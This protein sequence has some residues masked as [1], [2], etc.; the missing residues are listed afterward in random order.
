MKKLIRNAWSRKSGE[1][2][3]HAKI[4]HHEIHPEGLDVNRIRF[5]ESGS[6]ALE[7]SVGHLISMLRGIGRFYL[8]GDHQH[9]LNMQASVHAYIPPGSECILEAEPETELI[10]ISSPSSSQARGKKLVLRDE[11]YLAACATESQSLRWILTPQYL[12][13]RIFLHHDQ[14]LLSKAGN[15]ISLFHTTMFDV[16]GLPKNEEGESVFKMSY[17]SRTEV[18]FCYDV[19]GVARVRMAQHPYRSSKQ[20]WNPW[21]ALDGDSTYHLNEAAGGPEEECLLDVHTQTP[22]TWRNKHE[23]LILDGYVSLFCMFDPAPI[24]IEQ[25]Q[26]GEYTDYEPLSQVIKSKSYEIFS[27]EI[28]RYDE[29]LDALSLARATNTLQAWQGTPVWALYLQ[30]RKAQAAIEKRLANSLAREGNGR[31]RVLAR[32]LISCDSHH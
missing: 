8:K 22:T 26:P 18:N 25:H 10:C 9:P 11:T 4:L 14:T 21:L 30:G 16:S 19:Q 12:S 5:F 7:D 6:L 2:F 28:T 20:I 15:P 13:R 24:G 31:E 32:W 29:M 1:P 27:N 3:F 23:V 17:N